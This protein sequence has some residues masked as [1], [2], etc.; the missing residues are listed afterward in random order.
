MDDISAKFGTYKKSWSFGNL[1]ITP[2]ICSSYSNIIPLKSPIIQ[3]KESNYI[4][5][6][7]SELTSLK[8]KYIFMLIN[9]SDINHFELNLLLGNNHNMNYSHYYF[10]ISMNALDCKLENIK[11]SQSIDCSNNKNY[12]NLF[13]II[14]KQLTVWISWDPY[15]K[16]FNKRTMSFG[17][18][19]E[20]YKNTI[21][22]LLIYSTNIDYN[23]VNLN[24]NIDYITFVPPQYSIENIIILPIQFS[25]PKICLQG[26]FLS[27]NKLDLHHTWNDDCNQVGWELKKYS[28]ILVDDTI[29]IYNESRIDQC[30]I[31]DLHNDIS[32]TSQPNKCFHGPFKG[33]SIN[34]FGDYISRYFYVFTDIEYDIIE[35]NLNYYGLCTWNPETFE[36]DTAYVFVND[37]ALWKSAPKYEFVNDYCQGYSLYSDW[38]LYTEYLDILNPQLIQCLYLLDQICSYP[39]SFTFRHT[40]EK[41]LYFSIGMGAKLNQ[42]INNEAFG[43]SDVKLS[44]KTC[45]NIESMPIGNI[46][47]QPLQDMNRIF[48]NGD[49]LVISSNS[50]YYLVAELIIDYNIKNITNITSDYISCLFT[51]FGGYKMWSQLSNNCTIA[52]LPIM[53]DYSPYNGEYG[54]GGNGAINTNIFDLGISIN[55]FLSLQE[56]STSENLPLW[57]RRTHCESDKA[58]AYYSINKTNS[59]G[60]FANS[61]ANS[62]YSI[63]C[64]WALIIDKGEG[65]LHVI[66]DIDATD[67]DHEIDDGEIVWRKGSNIRSL[68]FDI[69]GSV[70]LYDYNDNNIEQLSSI[71]ADFM[72]FDSGKLALIDHNNN[73]IVKQFDFDFKQCNQ[74]IGSY[75]MK[76]FYFMKPGDILYDNE[77][78]ISENC[79]FT[80]IV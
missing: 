55:G 67:G 71:G 13:E 40:S 48:R 74:S 12:L 7:S 73:K 21:A 70:N 42:A 38:T 31:T 25:M 54:T 46:T 41:D 66:K 49:M 45:P 23:N 69:D 36:K 76:Y 79:L 17:I 78:L 18:G 34:N 33:S 5:L 43:F 9:I 72:I 10:E 63:D 61:I 68:V 4:T 80:L 65:E 39:V 37:K 35:V 47:Y 50:R 77:A 58:Y 32:Y 15:N 8:Y 44:Y 30:Q 26:N 3:S 56:H 16:E 29:S 59:I 24:S 52:G 62:I 27:S 28:N 64:S 20:L 60:Y 57:S 14:T 6:S 2:L 19:A 51:L 22:E 1:S 11:L 53:E 75:Y